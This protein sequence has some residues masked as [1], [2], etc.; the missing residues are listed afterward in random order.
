M[1]RHAI[2]SWLAEASG[3]VASGQSP[4][5]QP[6][7]PPSAGGPP[8]GDPN[9]AN[10]STEMTPPVAGQQQNSPDAANKSQEMPDVSN[11]PAAPDMPEN[12]QNQDFE[13]WKN[14]FFKESVRGDVG[15][16]I[17]MIQNIRDAKLEPYPRKFVEDNLQ[18]CFLRQNANIDKACK[19]I[20]NNIKQNLD[21][22][23][24]SV[25]VVNHINTALQTTPDM[26]N[27]FIKLKGLLG[28]KGDLH[29][30]YL[31]SLLGAVQV[32]SGGNNE[33]LIYNERDYS[34]R[35]STRFNDKWG[36][37][38]IGKWSL[39]EDD[40][41]RYLTEPEQKR[42]DD[43]SPEEKDVLR[44]RVVM[45]AI[46]ETF[47]KRSFIINVVG[48][49]GTIHTLGWDMAVSL[50]NAYANGKLIVKTIQ[51]DNSEA[52]IDEEGTIIPYVD[53]K[54]K[55]VK[56]AEGGVDDDG[57]PAK[58]EHEFMER[59]DGILFLTAQFPILKEASTSFGGI[60]LKEIPY[61]GNPSDLNVLMR[62]VPSAPEILLRNC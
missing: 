21:Q 27:I 18:I 37:V 49:D 35:I 2:N 61:T 38:D 60:V 57:R 59:I 10:P 26:N 50:R 6:D 5:G 43:G 53:I 39:R 25:S 62:C 9:A 55:Y 8:A 14:E 22:N 47:K 44:R 3:D 41:E 28:M 46:A 7:S 23:N 20:R 56:D 36:K 19:N 15:K 1:S 24:P 54:I 58:E 4:M 40:P 16:L 12:K 30:K 48:T 51:G 11:D 52:M 33:D 29:R 17:E 32:G 31:C 34:I 42:M 45:E 13:T